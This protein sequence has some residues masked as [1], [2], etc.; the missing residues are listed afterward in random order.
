MAEFMIVY[1]TLKIC[2]EK[3]KAVNVT[4]GSLDK[5]TAP[6]PAKWNVLSVI[7]VDGSPIDWAA[8]K[9]GEQA[10]R[11]VKIEENEDANRPEI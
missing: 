4:L 11:Y 2:E 10:F 6:C 7:C 5:L 1:R 9:L 8:S 3:E